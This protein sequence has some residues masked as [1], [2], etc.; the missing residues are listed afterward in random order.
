VTCEEA[1]G[2]V[3]HL[4]AA[5]AAAQSA[6]ERL[7]LEWQRAAEQQQEQQQQELQVH[8]KRL[9]HA[10]GGGARLL[11]ERCRAGCCACGCLLLAWRARCHTGGL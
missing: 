2:K 6:M 4:T 8:R 9:E 10:A 1:E 5:L 3:A 7:K 11:A